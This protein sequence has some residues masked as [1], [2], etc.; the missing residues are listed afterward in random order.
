MADEL[1]GEPRT[2]AGT[3]QWVGTF[4]FELLFLGGLAAGALFWR[5]GEGALQDW[6]EALYAQVAREMVEGGNWLTLSWN[7]QPYFKKPPLLFWTIALSYRVFDVSE[8]STRL[9]SVLFGLGS[10]LLVGLLGRQLYGR[11]IGLAAGTLLLTL[12]PFLTRGSRQSATDA[13][14]LFCSLLALFC[15][16]RGRQREPWLSGIG[17]T[18]GVG[19]LVKGVAALVPLLLIVLFCWRARELSVLRSG[20]FWGGIGGGLCCALPWYLYQV[21]L[22]GLPFVQTFV[23]GETLARL[24]TIYDAPARPWYFYFATLWG[25]VFHCLPLLVGFSL[26][27]LTSWWKKEIQVSPASHFL[28]CWLAGNLLIVLSTRTQH[29]WY[30][31]PVYPPLCIFIAGMGGRLA[32]LLYLSPAV[33]SSPG[34]LLRRVTSAA[35]IGWFLCTLPDHVKRLAVQLVWVDDFYQ[36]RNTLLQELSHQP[37]PEVPLYAVGVQMPGV[38]F[39]SRRATVFLSE[40]ELVSLSDLAPPLY[41][42]APAHLGE[43]L[44]EKGMSVLRQERDWL[45]FAYLPVEQAALDE[46]GLAEQETGTDEL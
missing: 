10:V 19:L 16:W 36:E 26:L 46:Q 7:A 9:P 42:L 41:A 35:A 3:K 34:L 1:V 5:L 4:F 14:L 17:I 30:L 25:D 31:L 29:A 44:G 15:A 28:F 40:V 6:D 11:F 38:V 33:R 23:Q 20:F 21:K 2:R 45:L 43:R 24:V 12:Y 37:D 32:S 18:I 39:Y 8:W 27:S 13:P 22:Y